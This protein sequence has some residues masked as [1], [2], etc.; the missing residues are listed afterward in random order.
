MFA[1][2]LEVA[3]LP[4]RL[5]RAAV[6]GLRSLQASNSRGGLGEGLVLFTLSVFSYQGE[7]EG[8]KKKR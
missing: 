5:L 4:G 7:D 8:E 1:P 3:L 2:E 6:A